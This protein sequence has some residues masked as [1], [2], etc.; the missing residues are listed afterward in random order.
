M[1]TEKLNCYSCGGSFAREELQFRPLAEALIAK[2]HITALPVT[3][4]K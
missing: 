4:G 1:E 2:W 3:K